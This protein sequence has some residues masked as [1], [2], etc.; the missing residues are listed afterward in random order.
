MSADG[1]GF[2]LAVVGTGRARGQIVIAGC[3]GRA[4]RM[5]LPWN[6]EWRLR[7]DAT[8]LKHW[9]VEALVTLMEK[10]ELTLM[11]LTELPELLAEHGIVWYHLPVG[12]ACIPDARF[13]ALWRAVSPQLCAILWRGGRVAVHCGDGRSR[14]PLVSAKLLIEFGCPINDALNR[15]RGARPGVLVRPEE[16]AFILQ[17]TQRAEVGDAAVPGARDDPSASRRY[18]AELDNPNQ[19]DLLQA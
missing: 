6:S 13:E 4:A 10:S 2:R 8:T 5:P 17:Q 15:I 3:P 18:P 12:G 11:R 7:R 14:A 9:G 19:L 16:H 1:S